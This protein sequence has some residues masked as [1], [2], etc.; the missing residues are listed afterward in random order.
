MIDDVKVEAGEDCTDH[1]L[2][3]L[4]LSV[5]IRWIRV[6]VIDEGGKPVP[7]CRVMHVIREGD[8]RSTGYHDTGADGVSDLMIPGEG[9]VLEIRHPGYRAL[10]FENVRKNLTVK[11]QMGFK[12]M[13]TIPNLPE[14]KIVWLKVEFDSGSPKGDVCPK[15]ASKGGLRRS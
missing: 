10:R 1:R 13:V 7:S 6:R 2:I 14:L 4:D 8:R 9:A 3:A 5:F 11:L 12:A 15:S